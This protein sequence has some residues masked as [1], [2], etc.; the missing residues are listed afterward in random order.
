[1]LHNVSLSKNIAILGT[2]PAY[3]NNKGRFEVAPGI[4]EINP[5][6]FQQNSSA[7]VKVVRRVYVGSPSN[8]IASPF[9]IFTFLAEEKKLPQAEGGCDATDATGVQA[10]PRH[11]HAQTHTHTHTYTNACAAIQNGDSAP[12]GAAQAVPRGTTNM[13]LKHDDGGADGCNNNNNNNNNGDSIIVATVGVGICE[14]L[15]TAS[16]GHANSDGREG[17]IGDGNCDDIRHNGSENVDTSEEESTESETSDM[18]DGDAAGNASADIHATPL[19]LGIDG[20]TSAVA[21]GIVQLSAASISHTAPSAVS[22]PVQGSVGGTHG[23]DTPAKP[24]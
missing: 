5:L 20:R 13:D 18:T 22:S 17:G 1:V 12:S 15:L 6:V 11:A 21:T 19:P 10:S 4:R 24:Q 7:Y 23:G 2:L 8:G 9:S 16:S 3:K 14:S